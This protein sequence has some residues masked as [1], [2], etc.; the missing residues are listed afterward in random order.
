MKTTMVK[1]VGTDAVDYSIVYIGIADATFLLLALWLTLASLMP[2]HPP[3][4]PD[5]SPSVTL[6][7]DAVPAAGKAS[8][9]GGESRQIPTHRLTGQLVPLGQTAADAGV[10]VE[11]PYEIFQVLQPAQSVRIT[12]QK[13]TP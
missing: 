11:V 7:S 1:S 9:E 2:A 13:T 12:T 10:I 4:N 5:S 3:A 8:A 6:K